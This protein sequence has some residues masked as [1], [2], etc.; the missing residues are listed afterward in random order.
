MRIEFKLSMPNIGSWNGKWSGEERY[1][2][3]VY[4]LGDEKAKKILEKGYYHYDFGDGWAAGIDVRKVDSKEAAK[5][6][7]KSVGFDGYDWMIDS[8]IDN[9]KIVSG[10]E[11][12]KEKGRCTY[13]E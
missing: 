4:I 11:D 1:Y 2:A 10:Q 13:D 6:R 9:G 5:L 3:R 8:I 7:K 12:D